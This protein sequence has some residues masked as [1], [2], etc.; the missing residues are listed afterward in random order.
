MCLVCKQ[1]R[2][3]MTWTKSQVLTDVVWNFN[4][5]CKKFIHSFL[6]LESERRQCKDNAMHFPKFGTAQHLVVFGAIFI[7]W[8]LLRPAFAPLVIHTTWANVWAGLNR[9][10]CRSRH[11]SFAVEAVLIHTI[12]THH[13]IHT[14]TEWHIP[15]AVIL[16]DWLQ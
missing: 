6:A 1:I 5:K 10:R 4:K 12:I 9:Q 3:E 8:F 2:G 14:I 15:Q 7:V 13:L 11:W 16:S